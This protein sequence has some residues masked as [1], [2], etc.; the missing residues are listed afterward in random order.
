MRGLA[1]QHADDTN[2]IYDE[3][4]TIKADITKLTNMF[5]D[6]EIDTMRWDIISFSSSLSNGKKFNREGYNHIFSVYDKYEAIL[7]ENNMENGLIEESIAY[8]REV[9]REGLKNGTI[10]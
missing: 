10:K 3:E 8:I 4:N 2:K 6:R 7:E 5:L 9:Y 1:K